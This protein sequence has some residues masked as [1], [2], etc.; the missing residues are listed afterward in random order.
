[1]NTI[2][3]DFET[4]YLKK[5]GYSLKQMIP[6]QYCGHELFDPYMLSVC[7]GKQ[8]WAGKPSE[9]NWSVLHGQRI[10]AHNARFDSVVFEEMQRRGWVSK[11]IQPAE[12]QCTANLS[13]YL[14]H[15]RS[16]DQAVEKLFKTRIS[17]Q[18]RED[19]NGKR[20]KDFSAEQ[21][22]T[23]L[24]YA[25]G[26]VRW[27]YSI[28][29]KFSAEWPTDERR[30]SQMTINQGKHGVAID[31]S[32]LATYIIQLHECKANIERTLPWIAGCHDPEYDDIPDKPTS[33]KAVAYECRKAKIPCPP[34]KSDDP[35]GWEEWAAT[36]T[37][38]NPWIAQL[39]AW[40]SVNKQL[41]RFEIMRERLLPGGILPFGLKYFGGHTGRWSGDS[42]IN[43]QNEVKDTL[44]INESGLLE[45]DQCRIV[46]AHRGVK[47]D[48]HWPF[49]VRHT[50]DPRWVYIPRPG[51]KM[52]VSDLSQIEPRVLAWL[53]K[54]H[55]FLTLVG[56]GFSPYEAFA[57]TKGGWTGGNLKKENPGKYALSKASVLGLGYQCGWEKFITMAQTLAGVDLTEND[58][59]TIEEYDPLTGENHIVSGRG[60]FSKQVVADFRASNP[61]IVNLWKSLDDALR[62]SIGS[63]FTITLPTGR[64]LR[65]DDVRLSGKIVQDKKTKKPV[66]KVEVTANVGGRRFPFYGGKLAENLTQAVAREVF[67]YHLL[68]MQD[69][70]WHNLFGVHDE[71]VQEVDQSVTAHDVEAAM[72]ECPPWLAGCPV[73]AE[74]KEVRHYLK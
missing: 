48:G 43:V 42:R 14:C 44:L 71:A 54:D 21:W 73:A 33:T 41:R 17:K 19:A 2:A 45:L 61:K 4:Y 22:Q 50:I 52:I 66:K 12:W 3:I 29:D 13:T 51:K 68:R 5:S 58:P 62:R 8:I 11:E 9:F 23:M 27:C 1:V 25:K 36:H 57:R 31:E 16:L 64:Q 7:D 32:L 67:A 56:Q 39:S 34:V 72:S 49:W 10:L 20:A 65:Y 47:E 53:I 28:W 37:P 74:A 38:A 18:A 30:L 35:E 6:E 24:E 55:D 15:R 69:R 70:G 40:R 46:A 26:D 60:A 63:D 59:E